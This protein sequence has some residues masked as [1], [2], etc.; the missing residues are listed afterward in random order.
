MSE[1]NQYIEKIKE[2]INNARIK[3]V[4]N[5][6]NGVS[7]AYNTYIDRYHALP[8]DE[9]AAAYTGRGG[10]AF[11][12]PAGDG[13]GALG[14]LV[15]ATFTP[16]PPAGEGAGFWQTLRAAQMIGGAATSAALPTN[17][18]GGLIGGL[19][20]TGFLVRFGVPAWAMLFLPPLM[21][22]S[23]GAAGKAWLDQNFGPTKQKP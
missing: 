4:V 20:F 6:L 2:L 17:A 5:D 9:L 7:A 22:F 23:C 15:G 11:A 10:G 8:G 19:L 13:N 18:V 1:T 14:V 16:N 12:I 21:A 3:N